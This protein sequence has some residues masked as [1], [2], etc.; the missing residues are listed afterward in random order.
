MI[1]WRV[2]PGCR[3]RRRHPCR[4]A[5]SSQRP[6]KMGSVHSF[7]P[8]FPH[9]FIYV[10]PSPSQV[11]PLTIHP[12]TGRETETQRGPDPRGKARTSGEA[13][14][15]L[16]GGAGHVWPKH[17]SLST[18]RVTI[19]TGFCTSC[20]SCRR[21]DPPSLRV[22]GTGPG[23]RCPER[24]GRRI[25]TRGMARP[26]GPSR[27]LSPWARS[28]AGH[29]E[30]LASHPESLAGHPESLLPRWGDGWAPRPR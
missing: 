19:G 27:L 26:P 24:V 6:S 2:P 12:S 7:L 14:P 23:R 10:F 13:E 3:V 4:L 5:E 1:V 17:P 18:P 30:S 11:P 16:K 25:C 9:A 28:L 21:P 15:W 22:P 20:Q 29:P 8:S